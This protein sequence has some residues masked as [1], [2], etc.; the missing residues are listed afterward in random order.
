MSNEG[1]IIVT[2]APNTKENQA[3]FQSGIR[4]LNELIDEFIADSDEEKTGTDDRGR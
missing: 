4:L 2:L 3:L 1:K